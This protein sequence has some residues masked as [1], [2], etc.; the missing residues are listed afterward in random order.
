MN[1]PYFIRVAVCAAIVALVMT[2]AGLFPALSVAGQETMPGTL[3]GD[4][5]I[6][7]LKQNGQYDALQTAMN[8]ARF[9]VSRAEDTPLGRY[10]WH[11]PNPA[12]GYDA[13]VTEEGVSIAVSKSY[14]S[15]SLQGIGYGKAL[16][17]VARGEV[18][19]DNQTINIRRDGGVQEWYVNGPDGLEQ[20]F[21]LMEAPGTATYKFA[22]IGTL[23]P[24]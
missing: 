9:A 17:A 1:L 12:A 21:T 3:H 14:V 8:H 11:A 13:Y 6:E 5:A 22:V 19:S 24:G 2:G 10:A 15:L 20:G 23:P 16:R 7:Q 18:S 4:A